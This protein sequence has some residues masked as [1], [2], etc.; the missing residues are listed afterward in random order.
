MMANTKM[1]FIFQISYATP[2]LWLRIRV[3]SDNKINYNYLSDLDEM[4]HTKQLKI[5]KYN[6]DNYYFKFLMRRLS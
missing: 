3:I 1:E 2:I 4:F 6:G 5:G